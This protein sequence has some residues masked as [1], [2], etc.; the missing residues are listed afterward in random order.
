MLNLK[1][2]EMKKFCVQLLMVT[3]LLTVANI[4]CSTGANLLNA[5][6]PLLSALSSVPSL[7]K[8]TSLLQT[9]GLDKLLGGALKDPFTMLAPTDEA[10]NSLGTDVVNNLT[11]PANISQLASLIQNHIVGGKLDAAGLAQSGLKAASGKAIDLAGA[12]LG[13][14]ISGDK[15]NIFPVNK[16]IQ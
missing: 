16:V 12:S 2:I 8:F 4:R 14:L 7:S 13:S 6:S 9:P 1:T 10:L 3:L 5:G 15:F 11:N